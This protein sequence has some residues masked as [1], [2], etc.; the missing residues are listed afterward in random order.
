M[1]RLVVGGMAAAGRGSDSH[2]EKN[3]I[4]GGL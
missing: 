3:D 4:I 2:T 1:K